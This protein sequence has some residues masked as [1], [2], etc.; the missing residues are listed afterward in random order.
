MDVASALQK[1]LFERLTSSQPIAGLV[2]RRVFDRVPPDA[3]TPYVTIS[4]ALV[5]DDG[6]EGVEADEIFQDV[7][8]WSTAEGSIEAKSIAGAIRRELRD[9]DLDLG[10]AHDLV[11]I[12]FRSLNVLDDPDGVTT[13]AVVTFLVLT[14][15]F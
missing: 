12:Q 5:S 6:A 10:E 2:G 8:V 1:A 7:H 14:E 11:E 3:P 4:K 15:S 9:A 13:H